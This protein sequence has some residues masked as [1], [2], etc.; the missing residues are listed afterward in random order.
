[1]P[2]NRIAPSEKLAKAIEALTE[3]E[4]AEAEGASLL[5]RLVQLGTQ[6]LVQE[7]LEREQ[8]EHLERGRYERRPSET[9]PLYRNGYELGRLLI[10]EGL[11]EVQRP[12][13]RGGSEPYRSRIW[14]LLGQRSEGLERL[15]VEMYARG[16]ST[17]DIEDLFRG[18]DGEVLLSKSSVSEITDELWE[19]YEAF[20]QRDLSDLPIV[21]LVVD[22]VY[23]AMRRLGQ[24][25]DGIL[26]AWGILEDG[27]RL[28]IHLEV[29]NR[30]SYESCLALL[31][32][33]KARGLRDPV[34]VT[35]DGAPGLIRAIDEVFAGSLRQRCLVHKKSNVLAKVTDGERAEVGTFLTAVYNAPTLGVARTLAEQFAAK[36]QGTF[37]SAV[38]VFLDDL[39]ACLAHL[40]CPEVHRKAIRTTN[41][42]ERAFEELRRRT[43]VIPRFF[44]ERSCLKLAFAELMRAGQRARRLRMSEI[45]LRQ[46]ELLKT[47]LA[48]ERRAANPR[49]TPARSTQVA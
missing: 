29:G 13:V 21:Y 10:G 36:Y 33:L 27:R 28:L 15:V 17:R 46:L 2:A 3:V 48:E 7:A 32:G 1:M 39:E 42:I 35:S 22:G 14:D 20:S 37:P 40:R 43:K 12:Q 44:N 8:A 38:R 6:K 25:R 45:E 23:E 19:E 24:V 49:R 30:E 31:R 26:V 11:I 4:N 9:S 34:L 5:G 16:L 41:V 18:P 47:E